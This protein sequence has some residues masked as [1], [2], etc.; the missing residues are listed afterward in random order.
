MVYGVDTYAIT[1][2]EKEKKMAPQFDDHALTLLLTDKCSLFKHVTQLT[3]VNDKEPDCVSL[4]PYCI[5][6]DNSV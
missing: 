5:I 1:M 6:I 3:K 4:F 2:K